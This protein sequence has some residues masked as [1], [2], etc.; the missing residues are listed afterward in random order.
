MEKIY[1]QVF[2]GRYRRIKYAAMSFLLIA[3]MLGSW[4]PWYRGNNLPGQ[5]IMIDLPQRK[6][7][8]FDI[9]IWPEELYYLTFMLILAAVGLFICTTLFGR[10]W[11]GYTCPHTTMVDLFMF[12]E[13]LFQ[14][15][16]NARIKLNDASMTKEK[17]IRKSLTHCTW[18]LVSFLFGFGWVGYFY[19]VRI[20]WHDLTQFS[21]SFNGF[22][23]LFALTATTYLFGGFLREKVCM[24]MCPY[25]RFQSGLIDRNTILV[26]YHDWRGEPRGKSGGDC[27]DCHRCVIACP[28]GIDIR[29]GLQMACIGCGLCIDACD[30][31]M[32]KMHRPKGLI[33]YTSMNRTEILKSSNNVR[34]QHILFTPKIILYSFVFVIAALTLITSLIFK[35][36]ILFQVDKINSPLFT[37]TPTGDIR[38]TYNISLNNKITQIQDNLCLSLRGIDNLQLDVQGISSD[39][40][41][42]HCFSLQPNESISAQVFVLLKRENLNNINT[43]YTNI[44]FVLKNSNGDENII[45]SAFYVGK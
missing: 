23:W 20:L 22:I 4:I 44:Q 37:L 2:S 28:M 32:N 6:A 3:Y 45:L 10:L 16:R 29:N 5:A 26:T 40:E 35:T 19:D 8:F 18:L 12:I 1:T 36:P 31:V 7:Y 41:N 17:F 39:F 30:E 9:I 14:G 11:C 24:H 21:V 25:G 33:E 38:N 43:Q 42:S 34:M 15:D 27:V 13:R